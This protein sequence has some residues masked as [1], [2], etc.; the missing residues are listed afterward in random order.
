MEVLPC[1]KDSPH[2]IENNNIM[3]TNLII[4]HIT[5]SLLLAFFVLG[6]TAQ[7]QAGPGPHESY[8]PVKSMKEAE[9]I[10]VGDHIAVRCGKC[11]EVTTMLADKDRSYLR[12]YHCE[13]CHTNFQL[14]SISTPHGSIS[15]FIYD[16]GAGHEATL[17]RGK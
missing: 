8:L 2:Q 11:G 17:L 10:K 16:D 9:Q 5:R 6:M 15:T 4:S 13:H 7:A 1:L 14:K 12:G 3:K